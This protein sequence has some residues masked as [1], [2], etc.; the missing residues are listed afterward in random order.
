M[1]DYRP[2]DCALYARLELAVLR[3]Q[4]VMLCWRDGAGVTHLER[5][6]PA[7]LETR[8]GEEFLHFRTAAGV[9]RRARLDRI[10][11]FRP[12]GHAAQR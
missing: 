8:D 2:V 11:E 7:D 1:T 9:A 6:L 4:A 12:G 10:I 5:V 3:R